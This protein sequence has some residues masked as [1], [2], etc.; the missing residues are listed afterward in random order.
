MKA[1]VIDKTIPAEELP[2]Q[3][4]AKAPAP[5]PTG[6]EIVIDV[7]T[8]AL[9]FFDLLQVQDK[10][11]VKVCLGDYH[12]RAETLTLPC[13]DSLARDQRLIFFCRLSTDS[14]PNLISLVAR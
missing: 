2:A 11:Q 14:P 8:A 9:N 13:W 4:T 6:N 7:H 10:Y 3:L 5:N 1:Y 12:N